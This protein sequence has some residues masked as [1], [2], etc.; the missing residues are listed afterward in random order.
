[1]TDAL[2]FGNV[3]R[4]RRST[5]KVDPD[6]GLTDLMGTAELVQ[7]IILEQ[8]DQSL[9]PCSMACRMARDQVQP[10]CNREFP[11]LL[12]RLRATVQI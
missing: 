11:M 10:E 8:F 5:W 3:R 7:V 1:M 4:H 9:G 6:L 12:Q 2:E